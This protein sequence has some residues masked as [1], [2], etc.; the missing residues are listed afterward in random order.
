VVGVF[1]LVRHPRERAAGS[2]DMRE[3]LRRFLASTSGARSLERICARSGLAAEPVSTTSGA[4]AARLASAITVFRISRGADP[5]GFEHPA[6]ELGL[7][8]R[9][10][11]LFGERVVHRFFMRFREKNKEEKDAKSNARPSDSWDSRS[12]FSTGG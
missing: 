12:R 4:V 11:A 2:T 10:A 8:E 1:L 3:P 9:V 5:Q 6:R 7:R